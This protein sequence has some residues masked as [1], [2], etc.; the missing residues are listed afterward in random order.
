MPTAAFETEKFF[1]MPQ[2]TKGR[3]DRTEL[4]LIAREIFMAPGRAACGSFRPRA[5]IWA[6]SRFPREWP[7]VLGAMPTGRRFTSPQAPA[8]I[9]FDSRWAAFVPKRWVSKLVLAR[10]NGLTPGQSPA[11]VP[12]VE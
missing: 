6:P 1:A 3:A 9:G 8:S 11:R 10:S 12:R 2:V 5:N 7:T 4:N